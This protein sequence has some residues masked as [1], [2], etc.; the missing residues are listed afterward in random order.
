MTLKEEARRYTSS[1]SIYIKLDQSLWTWMK[2]DVIQKDP[3]FGLHS[4]SS[5]DEKPTSF[6]ARKEVSKNQSNLLN[7]L[8]E[9]LL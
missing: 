1:K 2:C 8:L 3:P 6:L 9:W 7:R 5:A 4:F